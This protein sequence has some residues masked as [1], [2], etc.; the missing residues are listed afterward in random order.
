MSVASKVHTASKSNAR[1]SPDKPKRN[2]NSSA[3]RQ[4]R[5]KVIYHDPDQWKKD[6]E[7]G[8]SDS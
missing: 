4:L 7:T 6:I 8:D 5:K 2:L 1:Q 3:V